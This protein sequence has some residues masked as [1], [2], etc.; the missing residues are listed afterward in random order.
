MP[1]RLPPLNALRAFEAAGRHRSF[2]RAA[3]ELGVTPA[4][5]SHQIKLLEGYLGVRL[6]R[7]RP[8][9]LLLTD[10]G[11]Q[12][13]P[14]VADGFGRLIAAVSILR[15]ADSEQP[16]TVTV[17]PSFAAKWLVPRI[18]GFRVR[19]PGI[20]VRIDATGRLADFHSED[21]DVGIRH[22]TGHYPGLHVE[23][24]PAQEVFPVCSPAL[25]EGERPLRTP[26]DLRYH[27]LLHLYWLELGDDTMADWCTW[28][29]SAGVTD[30]DP[31]AGPRFGQE[32]MALQ[33]AVEGHGVA[34]VRTYI[35]AGD[36]AAGR[37]VRPFA[38]ALPEDFRHFLVCLPER[39]ETTKVAA[40]RTWIHNELAAGSAL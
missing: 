1:D 19:H 16:L 21:V 23:P 27:T 30:I 26:A 6:F 5:V 4:A 2:T 13:L 11:Q 18:E 38:H 34:L 3:S 20:E 22:G 29:A 24:L 15:L 37:V 7:R 31:R 39:A 25:L 32:S 14:G 9:G 8:Q 36:L 33:A 28:L 10:A 17:Q 35:A 12:A 40:F